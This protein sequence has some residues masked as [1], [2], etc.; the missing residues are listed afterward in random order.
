MLSA[1]TGEARMRA[2]F[3]I[4]SRASL[5]RLAVGAL[6]LLLPLG[7][8]TMAPTYHRPEAP[9]PSA[10]PASGT[11]GGTSQAVEATAQ[12]LVGIYRSVRGTMGE[13]S[14]GTVDRWAN[15]LGFRSLYTWTF[16]KKTA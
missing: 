14:V 1:A 11:L 6:C 15:E 8:C 16:R 4:H 5:R 2:L 3:R 12:K 7:G 9:I 13:C 10:Y